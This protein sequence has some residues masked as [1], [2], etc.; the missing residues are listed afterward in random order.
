MAVPASLQQSQSGTRVRAHLPGTS[1]R[2]FVFVS[3]AGL[4]ELDDRIEAALVHREQLAGLDVA[5][6]DFV[7]AQG[8]VMARNERDASPVGPD[9]TTI[10]N[11][12]QPS[13]VVRDAL[14]DTD[15]LADLEARPLTPH[16]SGPFV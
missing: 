9:L 2:S 8:L 4:F 15:D 1:E 12:G 13:L 6:R 10:N 16:G 14:V 11:A 7:A 5:Q 3:I